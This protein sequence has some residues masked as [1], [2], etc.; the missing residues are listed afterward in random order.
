MAEKFE[1]F[2]GN[3]PAPGELR[4]LRRA[5]G[6]FPTGVTIV[7]LRDGA[8]GPHGL[9]VNSFSSLSLDPPL[10]LW[11]LDS[12]SETAA[13]FEAGYP[14]LVNILG[15]SQTDLALRFARSGID[16]FDGTDWSEGPG[17]LPLLRGAVS[18]LDCATED[19]HI[20]GDH[21]III[22][23]VKRYRRGQGNPLIFS[24]GRYGTFIPGG[25]E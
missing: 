1:T 7:T 9:T 23:R 12:R 3:P 5:L 24:K 19:V 14:F 21:H 16:R 20:G 2:S 18:W 17:G 6:S 10:I 25:Q 22:G 4:H 11:C 15:S 8:G 13:L